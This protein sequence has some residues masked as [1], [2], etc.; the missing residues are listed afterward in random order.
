MKIFQ[1]FF[2]EG[3]LPLVLSVALSE[4]QTCRLKGW[5]AI[6]C[7]IRN[8]NPA[9]EAFLQA[10]GIKH[11]FRAIENGELRLKRR[12]LF[13]LEYL[14]F[15]N[16]NEIQ[17]AFEQSRFLQNIIDCLESE[18]N[19]VREKALGVLNAVI[20]SGLKSSILENTTLKVKMDRLGIDIGRLSEDE[21]EC[22]L[23]E[24]EQLNALKAKLKE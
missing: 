21:R 6:S 11:L 24:I 13:L 14:I 22:R 9:S 18:D 10:D 8:F 7:M 12:G 1:A 20:H 2:D 16:G 19:D 23:S 4:D 15:E 3:L 5:M 17:N